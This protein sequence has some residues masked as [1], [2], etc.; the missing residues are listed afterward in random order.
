M[1]IGYERIEDNWKLTLDMTYLPYVFCY[2]RQQKYHGGTAPMQSAN[3]TLPSPTG[4]QCLLLYRLDRRFEF[5]MESHKH[6]VHNK[7]QD[8]ELSSQEY[9]AE[10]KSKLPLQV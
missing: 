2:K 8:S 6:Y 9:I 10:A 5:E 4:N 3:K 1:W 7:K